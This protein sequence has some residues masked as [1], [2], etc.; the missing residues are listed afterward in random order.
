[1]SA[2]LSVG[3]IAECLNNPLF[4]RSF[5]TL[6]TKTTNKLKKNRNIVVRLCIGNRQFF[7]VGCRIL[8]SFPLQGFFM[9]VTADVQSKGG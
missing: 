7:E 2:V 6:T 4:S 3:C 9:C 8:L 5:I 1:M